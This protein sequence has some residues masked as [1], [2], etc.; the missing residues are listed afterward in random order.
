MLG[1]L[2]LLDEVDVV[3][4]VVGAVRGVVG[5]VRAVVLDVD[6]VAVE[7]VDESAGVR[8]FL[9]GEILICLYSN[10]PCINCIKAS[11][12]IVPLVC[13]SALMSRASHQRRIE[14]A[15]RSSSF[16]IQNR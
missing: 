6:A 14:R 5:V 8:V 2:V 7:L 12:S 1:V 10:K 4:G 11:L 3:R 9:G 16:L 13:P 15:R